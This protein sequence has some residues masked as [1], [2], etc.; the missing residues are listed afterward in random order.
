MLLL[1][2]AGGVLVAGLPLSTVEYTVADLLEDK[3]K[4]LADD[5]IITQVCLILL[6]MAL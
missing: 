3:W 2:Y 1:K 4:K 6:M 5:G